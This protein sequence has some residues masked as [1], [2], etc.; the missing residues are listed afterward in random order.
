MPPI[1]T[2]FTRPNCHLCHAARYVIE[3]VARDVP[4]EFRE[5]NIDEP[6]QENWRLLYDEH[7]PVVHIN[8]REFAR[9]RV[10]ESVLRQALL[11]KAKGDK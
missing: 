7:I 4:L 5:M 1:V 2:L 8:G 6:G 3:R 10:D 11:E 9:H